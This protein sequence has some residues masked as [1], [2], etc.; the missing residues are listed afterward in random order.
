M[1]SSNKKIILSFLIASSRILS[2]EKQNP[3]NFEIKKCS[4]KP[5]DRLNDKAQNFI[6]EN[7]ITKKNIGSESGISFGWNDPRVGQIISIQNGAITKTKFN[8][9][10]L[11]ILY[12]GPGCGGALD[13]SGMFGIIEKAKNTESMNFYATDMSLPDL[14]IFEKTINTIPG[15]KN[16]K[17]NF[18]F[19]QAAFC[20]KDGEI[21]K[22]MPEGINLSD[23]LSSKNNQKFNFIFAHNFFHFPAKEPD[24]LAGQLLTKTINL[25]A[26]NGTLFVSSVQLVTP[27]T[28]I[29]EDK[30]ND[31][32]NNFCKQNPNIL[33][34]ELVPTFFN[35]NQEIK[36]LYL[37]YE[38]NKG[39]RDRLPFFNLPKL[40]SDK[41]NWPKGTVL[42]RLLVSDLNNNA[43][44]RNLTEYI[45]TTFIE[46]IANVS[47]SKK[48]YDQNISSMM[49]DKAPHIPVC[50][51]FK[52][53]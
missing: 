21:I 18:H 34:K 8:G 40:L 46:I 45:P 50:L 31:L 3:P 39:I 12:V 49:N 52:N 2:M 28:K 11:N 6:F 26:E 53:T 47:N 33:Y 43:I 4:T 25:L 15:I 38:A 19:E 32:F 13:F 27:E 51:I 5:L 20:V 23:H 41:K 30:V 14:Y 36:K 10:P 44:C 37:N 17:I 29:L 35:E 22:T 24:D 48:E 42:N 1:I 9:G 7:C 16:Q